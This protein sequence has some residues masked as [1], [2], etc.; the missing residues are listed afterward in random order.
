MSHKATDWAWEQDVRGVRQHVL[1][2]LAERA[3]RNTWMCNPSLPELAARTGLGEST[4]RGHL[5][6]ME[7]LGL[8]S[9][10]WSN[11]GRRKRSIFT[12]LV[13]ETPQELHGLGTPETPQHV[14]PSEPETPQELPTNP[15]GAGPVVLRT[16]TRTREPRTTTPAAVASADVGDGG[17]FEVD[18]P[19]R[20]ING[21]VVVKAWCDTWASVR[22]AKPTR[23]Q[24]NQVG[25]EANS[26]LEAGN[27]PGSVI[28]AAQSAARRGFS[29]V[30][31]ELSS[32]SNVTQQS[33]RAVGSHV[34]YRN[35]TDPNAYDADLL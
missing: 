31:R 25:R 23:H 1:L 14:D 19:P 18:A 35:P 4:I 9:V 20:P 29:G 10:K 21:G 15:A 8:I 7:T 30:V 5:R 2:A 13:A 3:N 28:A 16:N 33:G 11:G 17:L 22:T 27:D 26:L 34:P 12:L 24:T 32:I 6:A